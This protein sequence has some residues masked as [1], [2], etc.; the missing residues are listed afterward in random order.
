MGIRPIRGEAV[1]A[2]T[3]TDGRK[4]MILFDKGRAVSADTSQADGDKPFHATRDA[5][6]STIRVGDERYEIPDEVPLGG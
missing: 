2:I 1:V 4:R 5:G 6:L 3:L